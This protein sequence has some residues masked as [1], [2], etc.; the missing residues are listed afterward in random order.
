MSAEH[1]A[2]SPAAAGLR[3]HRTPYNPGGLDAI[4]GNSHPIYSAGELVG[5]VTQQVTFRVTP[6]EHFDEV[7]GR[8]V[9]TGWRC[10]VFAGG[11]TIYD[12]RGRGGCSKL[13]LA[14]AYLRRLADDPMMQDLAM[15]AM[16]GTGGPVWKQFDTMHDAFMA[17][18]DDYY[19]AGT[20]RL[21]R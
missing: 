4:V 19:G 21:T 11:E 15:R 7:K 20:G 9:R 3:F 8:T 2:L 18:L 6:A 12:D 5:L 13:G 17:A 16:T 14:K 10:I 1:P